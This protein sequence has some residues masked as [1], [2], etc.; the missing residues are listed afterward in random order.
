MSGM[1]RIENVGQRHRA[2]RIEPLPLAHRRRAIELEVE[3]DHWRVR[4]ERAIQGRDG[5]L[6]AGVQGRQEQEAERDQGERA[7]GRVDPRWRRRR[8]WGQSRVVEEGTCQANDPARVPMRRILWKGRGEE[9]ERER[10]RR[11]GGRCGV[12]SVALRMRPC[13]AERCEQI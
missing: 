10:G 4:T 11:G 8:R 1:H 13:A 7:G 3:R 5:A 6:D 2:W 12:Q 9:G